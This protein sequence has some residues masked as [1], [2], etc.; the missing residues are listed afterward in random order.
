MNLG[1]AGKVVLVSG[2]SRGIGFAIAHALAA[3]GCKLAL[4]ARGELALAAARERLVATAGANKVL[5]LTADMAEEQAITTTLDQVENT[6]GPIHAAV[7]NVGSGKSVLG[8]APG[9]TDWQAAFEQNLYPATLLASV[10]LP[11]LVNRRG[12]SL[13]LI[14]SIAGCEAISAPIPYSAA[15]AAINMAVKRYAQEVGHAGVRVN[16]V[17]PGNVF[18]PGGSWAEKFEDAARAEALGRYIEESVPLRRFATP[19]EVAD[20]VAFLISSR[21][22][23]VSGAIVPVDGGQLSAI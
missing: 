10:L 19:R 22:S 13:T 12:G 9:R 16:A 1:L 3:E 6:L 20:V 2:A 18:V 14:S 11:R 7:S 5:A 4:V 8:V 17:A 21:A 23:F 15:K